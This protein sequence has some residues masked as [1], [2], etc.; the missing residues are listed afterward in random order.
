MALQRLDRKKILERLDPIKYKPDTSE[1]ED[2]LQQMSM[3]GALLAL[4]EIDHD[5][6]YALCVKVARHLLGNVPE[7]EETSLPDD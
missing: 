5:R 7:P 4:T 1:A 3:A 2:R 6:E